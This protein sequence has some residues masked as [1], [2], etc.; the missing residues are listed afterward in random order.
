MSYQDV[1]I[2]ILQVLQR[3]MSYCFLK[4]DLFFS[5]ESMF[6]RAALTAIDSN[7]NLHRKQVLQTSMFYTISCS[8]FILQARGDTGSLRYD[9]VSNRAGSKW[10]VYN[11]NQS[12]IIITMPR[13]VRP[14]MEGKDDSWREAIAQL[15]VQVCS[16]VHLVDCL[17]NTSCAVCI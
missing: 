10:Y 15:V 4:S 3:Y 1:S 2:L 6:A 5:H 11:E 8:I 14:R 13:F 12:Q 7:S 16:L 9:L 17:L